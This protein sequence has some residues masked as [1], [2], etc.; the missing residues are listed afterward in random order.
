[1]ASTTSKRLIWSG[2]AFLFVF[3]ACLFLYAL[4][5]GFTESLYSRRG[6]FAFFV[7]ITEPVIRTFPVLD[8]T[9]DPQYHSGCG[10]GPKLPDQAISYRSRLPNSELLARAQR[11][12]T[13]CGYTLSAVRDYP[14]VAY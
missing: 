6:S 7:T 8:P 13:S 3:A 12:A 5:L 10:D 1:M 9:S 2:I 14:G 4:K 11:H